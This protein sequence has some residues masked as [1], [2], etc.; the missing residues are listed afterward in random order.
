MTIHIDCSL[1]TLLII[2]KVF[3]IRFSGIATLLL[4]QKLSAFSIMLLSILPISSNSL[5]K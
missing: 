3:N 1:P 4:P 2:D 5:F